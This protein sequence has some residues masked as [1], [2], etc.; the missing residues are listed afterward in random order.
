MAPDASISPPTMTAQ[1]SAE[2]SLD[3]Q[4][5]ALRFDSDDPYDFSGHDFPNPYLLF[6]L[7]PLYRFS[8]LL[9]LMPPVHLLFPNSGAYKTFWTLHQNLQLKLKLLL[10]LS[11]RHQYFHRFHV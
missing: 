5:H 4:A 3:E 11:F 9:I 8:L 6:H 7:L 10:H 2:Q 1:S